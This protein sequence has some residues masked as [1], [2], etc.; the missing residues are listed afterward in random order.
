M[1]RFSPNAAGTPTPT[2][3]QA[4]EPGVSSRGENWITVG[5][6]VKVVGLKG[7]VKVLSN[8]DNPE[9]FRKGATLFMESAT[10]DF[11]E[12]SI[13]DSRSRGTTDTLDLLFEGSTDSESAKLFIGKTLMI[14][15]SLRRD[16]PKDSFYPDEVNGMTVLAADGTEIGCVERLE[17]QVPSPYLVIRG[18]SFGEVMIPFRKIFV[19]SIDRVRRV[20]VLAV[21]IENHL[22]V[23]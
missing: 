19:A 8:S 3:Q 4:G 13:L 2:I 6:V 9:R 7:W 16:P 21:P 18:A 22:P 11:Q 1:A 17:A 23:E 14:P 20:L 5:R 12:V 15:F 10:G